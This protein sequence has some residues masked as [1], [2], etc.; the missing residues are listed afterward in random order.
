[1]ATDRSA[2]ART[3]AQWLGIRGSVA[4]YISETLLPF[5]W[6]AVLSVCGILPLA[7]LAIVVLLPVA[8][9]NCRTMSAYKSEADSG[10]IAFLDQMSAQLQLLFCVVM[11]LVLLIEIWIL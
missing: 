5:V 10:A 11:T 3:L 6:I 9:R 4:L 1:M 2:S 7:S 8:L